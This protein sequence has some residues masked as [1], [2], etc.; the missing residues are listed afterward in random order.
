VEGIPLA[1]KEGA[2]AIIQDHWR[3]HVD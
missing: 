3:D 2:S 1:E